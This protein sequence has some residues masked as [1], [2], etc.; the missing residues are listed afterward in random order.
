MK[1]IKNFGEYKIQLERKVYWGEIAQI[2]RDVDAELEKQRS[3]I[4]KILGPKDEED[5]KARTLRKFK[6]NSIAREYIE[7]GGVAPGPEPS[8]WDKR[9]DGMRHD[10]EPGEAWD[11]HNAPFHKGMSKK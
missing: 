6:N 2:K 8:D 5:A 4:G 1:R 7:T 3:K 9:G 10:N 11:S